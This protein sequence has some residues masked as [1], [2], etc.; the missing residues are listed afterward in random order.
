MSKKK[1][2]KWKSQSKFEQKDILFFVLENDG[3]SQTNP[4]YSVGLDEYDATFKRHKANLMYLLFPV[5]VGK[6]D[7]QE[8]LMID[9][10]TG[11]IWNM[12]PGMMR[13]KLRV[14]VMDSGTLTISEEVPEAR[15]PIQN[16]YDLYDAVYSI[17]IMRY[18]NTVFNPH[19]G[20]SGDDTYIA[21]DF[22]EFH[23]DIPASNNGPIHIHISQPDTHTDRNLMVDNL[24]E[25]FQ[26]N[27]GICSDLYSKFDDTCCCITADGDRWYLEEAPQPFQSAY[28]MSL[29]DETVIAVS[30]TMRR[31]FE[32]LTYG[33]TYT[34]NSIL[35]RNLIQ[36]PRKRKRIE[37]AVG[38]NT[39]M[40]YRNSGVSDFDEKTICT[41]G[42]L[43]TGTDLLSMLLIMPYLLNCITIAS[44]IIDN[45]Y[46]DQD[47]YFTAQIVMDIR[48]PSTR[49]YPPFV[50]TFTRSNETKDSR[51]QLIAFME[52]VID[53]RFRNYQAKYG[54]VV[55]AQWAQE[56]QENDKSFMVHPSAVQYGKKKESIG[57][58]VNLSQKLP[59]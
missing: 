41:T 6:C 13:Y 2:K 8:Y 49:G 12:T 19:R 39:E 44:I 16:P 52:D 53:G 29:D 34:I 45:P 40:K 3:R 28:L 31:N 55:I 36:L 30:D 20:I 11:I 23:L 22:A 38:Y 59:F 15:I 18:I 57:T 10:D 33:S 50:T 46:R 4:I 42:H 51:P 5:V 35:R 37:E 25:V 32:F 17:I 27:L 24:T 47:I 7:V 21:F 56:E 48:G 1:H 9:G 54:P 58:I 14:S 26:Y 43:W